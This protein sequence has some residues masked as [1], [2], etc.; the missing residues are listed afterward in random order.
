[1]KT[2]HFYYS[3]FIALM[4]L[5]IAGCTGSKKE[6]SVFSPGED[7]K[8]CFSVT[9]ST[10]QYR[11]SYK[12]E[13]VILP[14]SMGLEMTEK[15]LISEDLTIE[16]ISDSQVEEQYPLY[17]G[18]TSQVTCS[19]NE[20]TVTLKETAEPFRTLKIIFR[21]YDDGVAFRY[22][23]PGQD[24]INT[25]HLK[26]EY[27]Q[28]RLPQQTECWKLELGSFRS[29]YESH[30]IKCRPGQVSTKSFIGLP[31]TFKINNHI[32]GAIA[33]AALVNY[34]GMYIRKDQRD[35]TALISLLSNRLDDVSVAVKADK[36]LVT[37]W[38]VIM[39]GDNETEL[40]KSN[41]ITSLNDPC[42]IEDPS[43]IKP[44]KCAWD[45]WN[46]QTVPADADFEGG[47]N[48]ETMKYFI[49]FAA[50]YNLE[51]MLIDAEWYGDHHDVN[52]DITTCIPEIDI[53]A[54]VDYGKKQNVDIH[55]WV[56]WENLN[57]QMEKAM[58]VYEKW[59]VKGIKID[60]M[61]R[62]DQEMV[63]FYHRTLK[64]AAKH[65]LM[66]NFH[67]AY[68]PTGIRRT[69]PN[70]MTREGIYGLEMSR[71][72][73]NVTP[74]HNVTI[75]F[76]RM[77]VGPMD[78]TPGGFSNVKTKDFDP[79]S[80]PPT[81]F[82]TRAH[83]LAMYVVYESPLQ[84]VSD[85]PGAYRG[86]TGGEFL[87]TVPASWDKTQPIDGE[88]GE[89]IIMA[90]KNNNN[91]YL[92][93]M[94]NWDEKKYQVIPSENLINKDGEKGGLHAA[95]YKGKNYDQ[96]IK[97]QVD[98]IIDFNWF[99]SGPEDLPDDQYSIRWTGNI[100]TNTAGEY[101]FFTASDDGVRLWINNKLLI[102]DWNKHGVLANYASISLE[103]DKQ[104]PVKLEYFEDIGGASVKF[105][106]ATPETL[107]RP[108]GFYREKTVALD[109]LDEDITY[110]AIVYKDT[111]ATIDDPT[112]LKKE[113]ISVT[114]NDQLDIKMV[115]GGGMAVE[116]IPER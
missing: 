1:M 67:G 88:I 65:K 31:L 77:L 99:Q 29:S 102:D 18:K 35:S 71:G 68:K 44:G 114:A 34:A 12:G 113:I 38:R 70:L 104:Y 79:D 106:W 66:I 62:D 27:T 16:D 81:V 2:K 105:G 47:M 39:L 83:Q 22:I 57:N 69:Y 58:A 84:M 107:E 26:N 61:N 73:T 75:P 10:P 108:H 46:F 36:E 109:F 19:F 78:Y 94:S 92:G 90:R 91:C 45:W 63:D 110:K 98:E 40:I 53:P 48:N 60:Y 112:K 21:V 37:P 24:N 17:A 100:Q 85:W 95:Y 54:L 93:A 72:G 101:E 56:N 4:T 14:S 30:F 87:K 103:A 23:V 43:W 76:T 13:A 111:E 50:E 116:F 64:T 51:Y 89:Y 55:V 52:E 80:E 115:E 20:K 5:I 11:I 28:F 33:E 86:T 41:I 42:V 49:D 82:G 97:E 6:L 9:N 74:T 59:G 3:F 32:A 96:L 7:I 25:Y 15:G 8:L